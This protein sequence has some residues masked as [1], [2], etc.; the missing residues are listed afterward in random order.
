MKR[1]GAFL[2]AF[3]LFSN[4]NPTWVYVDNGNIHYLFEKRGNKLFQG[5][6]VIKSYEL[7]YSDS[8]VIGTEGREHT[9]RGSVL[10]RVTRTGELIVINRVKLEDAVKSVLTTIPVNNKNG[11]LLKL[12]SV[13]ARTMLMYLART[14]RY[15]PDSTDFFVYTGRDGEKPLGNFASK[16]TTGEILTQN[17]SIIVPFY[18]TNSGGVTEGGSDIGCPFGYLVPII[19]TFAKYGKSFSWEKIITEDSLYKLLRTRTLTPLEVTPSGRVRSFTGD[20]DVTIDADTVKKLLS[21]PSLLI[22]I[23]NNADTLIIYGRGKGSGLGISME[24]ADYMTSHGL[25]YIDV[26]KLFYGGL[27]NLTRRQS[28]E[29]LYRI[30]VV[31]YAQ[32]AGTC[33]H[34]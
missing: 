18:H 9:Y 31:Q 27:V 32:K 1:F 11:E 29:E 28:Y 14:K 4:L 22:Y 6:I 26:I 10:I 16:F 30:P 3:K 7:P 17:D 24:S 2:L 33:A 34:Y 20:N 8:V 23:E 15:I 12:K 25:S 13:M 5:G 21:L 19:D